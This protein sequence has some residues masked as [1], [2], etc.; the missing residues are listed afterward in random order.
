M[1]LTAGYLKKV[2]EQVDDDVVLGYLKFN[3]D[4]EVFLSVKRLLLCEL[5]G[6]KFL[7][8]N[9]MGSHFTGQ[10]GLKFIGE[11]WDNES[12]KE[13]MSYGNESGL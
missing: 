5:D 12:F 10:S 2:L 1:E 8:I 11:F 7:M 9:E 3:K 13:N 6:R 4:I